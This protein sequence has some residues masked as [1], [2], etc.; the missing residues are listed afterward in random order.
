M[1]VGCSTWDISQAIKT[2]FSQNRGRYENNIG[3]VWLRCSSR[4][5][6]LSIASDAAIFLFII[7]S[8]VIVSV[9]N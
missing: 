9:V 7:I 5:Q 6:A 2:V 8:I 3:N 4:A 1:N